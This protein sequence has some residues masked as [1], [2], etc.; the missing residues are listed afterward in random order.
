[1]YNENNLKAAAKLILRADGL[2]LT[3]GAG[4]GVDSGLPDFRGD[5]GF[6]RAYPAL[7]EAGIRFTDVAN[8]LTF[9]S[10]P[11]RAWGFYGHRLRLYR[12]TIPNEGY[13][14]VKELPATM[15]AGAFVFTSNVDGQFQQAGFVNSRIVEC[16][17]SIHHLQC[18]KACTDHIWSADVFAPEVDMHTCRLTSPLPRCI[19][20]PNIFMFDDYAWIHTR[21]DA[22]KTKFASWLSTVKQLVVIEIG[23]GSDIS[24]V[25]RRGEACDAPLIRINPR[26]SAVSRLTD[27]GFEI[28]ALDGLRLLREV[29]NGHDG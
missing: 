5:G 13:A 20:R 28:G 7:G 26:E 21:T 29:I 1:M 8:G 18:M 15:N 23:A 16:H 4:M 3:A 19:A 27:V 6:Y 25:R 14:I 17:G 24:T 11:E 22:Q 9:Q 2:L 10:N 12:D